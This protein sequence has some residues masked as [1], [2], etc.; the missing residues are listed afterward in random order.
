[1]KLL[2]LFENTRSTITRDTYDLHL[3]VVVQEGYVQSPLY[4]SIL[5]VDIKDYDGFAKSVGEN[6]RSIID[7]TYSKIISDYNPNEGHI[8]IQS[9]QLTDRL[10]DGGSTILIGKI[11]QILTMTRTILIGIEEPEE[12]IDEIIRSIKLHDLPTKEECMTKIKRDHTI[13]KATTRNFDVK[14]INIELSISPKLRSVA[15]IILKSTPEGMDEDEVGLKLAQGLKPYGIRPQIN[16][17]SV[18][19]TV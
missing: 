17:G 9:I 15:N 10:G 2:D 8:S 16:G 12:D 4:V 11:H 18:I 7:D 5:D 19:G 14:D 1:M 6:I 13:V 3:Y